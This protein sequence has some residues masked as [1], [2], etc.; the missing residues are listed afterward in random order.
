MMDGFNQSDW[1]DSRDLLGFLMA[2]RSAQDRQKGILP[3]VLGNVYRWDAASLG[4]VM[5]TV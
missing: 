5:A 3:T 2:N 1:F 4:M